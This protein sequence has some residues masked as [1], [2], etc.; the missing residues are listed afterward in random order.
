MIV[1]NTNVLSETLRPQSE[2]T[3]LDWLNE[4]QAETL[5]ISSVAVAEMMFGVVVLM[6]STFA[7]KTLDRPTLSVF[8]RVRLQTRYLCSEAIHCNGLESPG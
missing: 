4:Q 3:V 6:Q 8:S 1:L 5:F 2:A 7:V